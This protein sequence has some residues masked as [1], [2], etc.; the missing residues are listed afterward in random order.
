MPRFWNNVHLV[1]SKSKD[2]NNLKVFV[3]N[4]TK[5]PKQNRYNRL[6]SLLP[7]GG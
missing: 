7:E 1:H 4:K 6:S 2:W 3:T 5:G